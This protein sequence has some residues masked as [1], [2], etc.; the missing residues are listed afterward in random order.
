[1][2]W[3]TANTFYV[4]VNGTPYGPY[5]IADPI[6]SWAGGT[7]WLGSGSS[8][9][10]PNALYDDLRISSRA[11]TDQEILD[12]YNSNQPLQ[13]DKDTTYKLDMDGDIYIYDNSFSLIDTIALN[14]ATRN[15]RASFYDTSNLWVLA[16]GDT[17][18]ELLKLDSLGNVLITYSYSDDFINCESMEYYNNYGYGILSSGK[19]YSIDLATGIKSEL[20]DFARNNC[21][22]L[23]YN[24]NFWFYSDQRLF[25]GDSYG[26]ILS[27]TRF[28]SYKIKDATFDST[29]NTMYILQNN[30]RARIYSLSLNNVRYKLD[31]LN[32]EIKNN[33]IQFKDEYGIIYNALV[34]KTN[35]TEIPIGNEDKRIEIQLE[36]KII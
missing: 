9:S 32:N 2:K 30:P 3:T 29:N 24:N 13:T 33:L 20:V 12:A 6:T 25:Q 11:R 35:I 17:F 26:N 28:E 4:Y 16:K 10:Y 7:M 23:S 5:T 36:I 34:L 22:A 21:S 1:V 18:V 27:S 14:N 15:I 31:L 19:V 8:N